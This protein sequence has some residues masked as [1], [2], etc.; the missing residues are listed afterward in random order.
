MTTKLKTYNGALS[1]LGET[2]LASLEEERGARY[3]LDRAWADGVVDYCLEQGM[4]HFATRTQKMTA[5]TSIIPGFPS[6]NFAFEVPD[7]F[8]GVNSIWLDQLYQEALFDYDIEDGV[9]YAQW[10]T[11][12]L[13]YVSNAATY[14]GNLAMWPNSFGQYVQTRLAN[15]VQPNITNSET[16]RDKLDRM[17]KQA[18]LTALNNDKR[19]KKIDKNPMGDW[20]RSRL[21]GYGWNGYGTQGNSGI[22]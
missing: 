9:I 4:W 10:D 8:M 16:L 5:S 1:L 6:Y 22:S 20:S 3:W 19:D 15:E 12:Y 14:G 7:D 17:E 11:I 18:R 13:K 21:F 2:P